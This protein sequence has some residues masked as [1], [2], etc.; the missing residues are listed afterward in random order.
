MG[1][2][3]SATLAAQSLCM[4]WALRRTNYPQFPRRSA[5]RRSGALKKIFAR[6]FS[7]ARALSWY[8]LKG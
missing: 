2:A 4:D 7:A 3:L 5:K 8:D 1:C 6:I